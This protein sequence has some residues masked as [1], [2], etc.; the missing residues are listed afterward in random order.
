MSQENVELLEE[1]WTEFVRG[2]FPE[3]RFT[4][5]VTWQL[6]A[7]EPEG[8]SDGGP[9]RGPA[10]VQQMLAISSPLVIA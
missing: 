2:R 1:I 9:I 4:E 7:D 10:E 3:D 5:D 6:A 8:S